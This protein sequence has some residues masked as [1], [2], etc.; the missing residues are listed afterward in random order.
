MIFTELKTKYFDG[1]SL[2]NKRIKERFYHIDPDVKV[3]RRTARLTDIYPE[4]KDKLESERRVYE[5]G[6][7]I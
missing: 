2:F 6:I 4:Y 5:R 7:V 1:E 3:G